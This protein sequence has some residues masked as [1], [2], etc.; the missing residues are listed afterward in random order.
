VFTGGNVKSLIVQKD[1]TDLDLTRHLDAAVEKGAGLVC[2]GELATTGCLYTRREVPPLEE[3][4]RSFEPYDLR[5]MVG[6][7]LISAGH[8]RNSYLY[9]HRGAY[10]TY[11]KINLFPP[12]GEPDLYQPGRE[13]GLWETDFGRIAVAICY[14]LRFPDVFARLRELSVRT[15]FVPA[16]FPR[17]RITDWR[18]LLVQR[19]EETGA[20]VVGINSVGHDGRNEFGGRSMVVDPAGKVV[21]QAD[22]V[23]E[24]ALEADL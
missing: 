19:A 17:V 24:V 22:E 3:V 7:P 13:P 2:F 4:L 20:Y 6:L 9:Y 15:I 12:F 8:L 21:V 11:H 1:I 10:E 5:I 14:D 18:S 23:S 16:A